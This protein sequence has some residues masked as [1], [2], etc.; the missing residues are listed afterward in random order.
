MS[1]LYYY[2]IDRIYLHESNRK[3]WLCLTSVDMVTKLVGE[4]EWIGAS[5]IH[6]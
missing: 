3:N 6:V 5:V 2:S 1:T 4:C